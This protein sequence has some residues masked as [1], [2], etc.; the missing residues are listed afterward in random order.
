[1]SGARRRRRRP[2]PWLGIASTLLLTLARLSYCHNTVAIDTRDTLVPPISFPPAQNW[3]GIDGS[4]NTF[5]LLVGTP[6][7]TVRVEISTA[8]QQTW[9]V[10]PRG[11][12]GIDLE[13][14]PENR[15]RIFESNESS[16][17]EERGR[18]KL[19]LV[20]NLGYDGDADYGFDVVTLGG[21]GENGPTMEG[22]TVG[23]F[24]AEDFWFGHF[25]VNPKPTNFSSM[26]EPSPSYM[27]LLKDAG[28]IPSLSF[29]YTAGAQYRRSTKLGSL[30]GRTNC[31]QALE[32]FWPA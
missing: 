24:G 9:V 32:R 22:T 27:S 5:S 17:W 10:A 4:W 28:L 12:E 1:M 6:P 20:T 31:L 16:T 14:C 29:G 30:W 26:N 2:A 7:Q 21:Q 11:C 3:E 13:N 15:G 8:S 23:T 19:G 18:F 25:G